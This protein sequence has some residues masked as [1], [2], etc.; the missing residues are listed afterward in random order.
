MNEGF[1]YSKM[2]NA[3]G[4]FTTRPVLGK[5]LTTRE[6]DAAV[7]TAT[8]LPAA[9]CAQVFTTYL[10]QILTAAGD[11]RWS[12]SV[13]ELVRFSPVSGGSKPQADD[14]HSADDL[15]ADV[16][17]VFTAPVIRQWRQRLQLVGHG[18]QGFAAPVV[19]SILSASTNQIDVYVPGDMITVR[20]QHLKVERDDPTQGIFLIKPDG[21]ETRCMSYGAITRLRVT[22]LVPGTLSGPLRVRVASRV[23]GSVRSS[24]YTG[25]LQQVAAPVV[26]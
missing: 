17:L 6:L 19:A 1:H 13:H 5:Q 9:Q 21:T 15:A 10:Q 8:G 12:S 3:R 20:G 11:S 22:A 14:F 25:V 24:V 7:S 16:A 23:N 2:P 4:G 26:G 18:I